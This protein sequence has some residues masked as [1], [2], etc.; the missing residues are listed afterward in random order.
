M[1]GNTDPVLVRLEI[2]FKIIAGELSIFE[3][4][5]LD[6]ELEK[7]ITMWGD[8]AIQARLMVLLHKLENPTY[9]KEN[10]PRRNR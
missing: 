6:L 9:A 10:T 8:Q 4:N 1:I 7:L 2:E 3:Q 5:A